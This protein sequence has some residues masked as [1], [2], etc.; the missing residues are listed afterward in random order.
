MNLNSIAN[1]FFDQFFYY[2]KKN[3]R[4]EDFKSIIGEFIDLKNDNQH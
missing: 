4:S 2:I 3:N 1:G